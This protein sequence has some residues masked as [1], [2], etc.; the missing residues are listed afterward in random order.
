MTGLALAQAYYPTPQRLPPVSQIAA[1]T[2]HAP[3][4]A[5][6]FFTGIFDVVA[7]PIGLA[8]NIITSPFVVAAPFQQP[9]VA[10]GAVIAQAPYAAPPPPPMV[11]PP[12][13]Q[14]APGWHAPEGLSSAGCYGPHGEWRGDNN[15]ECGHD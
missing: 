1:L 11:F 7:A 12:P 5:E 9:A 8:I 14:K 13:L 4:P 6:M 10:G 2:V 15:P 3:S